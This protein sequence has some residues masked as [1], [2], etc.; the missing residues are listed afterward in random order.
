MKRLITMLPL[1][2][3]EAIQYGLVVALDEQGNVLGSYHA[4]EG[5]PANG[6]T[7]VQQA[8]DQI[9]MGNLDLPRIVRMKV[10]PGI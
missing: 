9:Y 10:P 6:V 5:A 8:G 7:S 2:K 1:P 4:P 3:P